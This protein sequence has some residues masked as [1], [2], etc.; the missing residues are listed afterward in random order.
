MP[1]GSLNKAQEAALRP[2]V[3]RKVVHDLGAGD[4]TLSHRLLKFGAEKVIAID[5]TRPYDTC[6]MTFRNLIA[7][8]KIE[9]VTGYFHQYH[10]PIDTAFVSWPSNYASHIDVLC[11]RAPTVIYLGV[12]TDGTCCGTPEMF[13]KLSKRAVL[14]HVPDR[15][16]TL[17]VYGSKRVERALLPEEFA[18]INIKKV[19]TYEEAQARG[20]V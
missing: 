13:E 20:S 16:N 19:W 17:I 14:A 7:G 18:A 3:K 6:P 12:N 4:Y 15:K 10:E 2:F 1:Y 8:M 9:F 5:H 11:D